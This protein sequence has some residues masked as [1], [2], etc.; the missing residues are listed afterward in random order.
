MIVVVELV[1][2]QTHQSDK[3]IN[4]TENHW[5]AD[6]GDGYY[7]NP[8]LKGDW[9][10]P[11]VLR[12]GKDYY[13]TNHTATH[14]T[15]SMLIWHSR[16]LVNWEPLGYALN[17]DL[18]APV[19]AA[20][21][22]KYDDLYY[23][24]LPV[25]NKGTIYVITAPDPAGPW[26]KP[27]D[28]GVSGID[29]G[30][31]A[32]PDGRRFLHVDAGYM[33]EL[34]SDGLRATTS[35]EKVHNGWEYPEDWIVECFCLES[36]KLFYKDGWYYLTVAQGGTAG[37]P[38]GHMIASS[39]SR[40]PYG[41]WEDSPFNPIV[42][43]A[44]RLEK[45]ASMGHG[46]LIDTPEGEWYVIFHSF[47]NTSRN[48]GRQVLM[49]PI[50]WTKEGWFRVPENIHPT[51]RIKMPVNGER[52]QSR[53][54]LS[55]SFL[56]DQLGLQ[57]KLVGSD[58]RERVVVGNGYLELISEGHSPSDS[59]PLVVD[60]LNDFYQVEVT[61]QPSENARNG[62]ILY[63]NNKRYLGL[64]VDGYSLY[65]IA[66]GDYHR[67]MITKFND[68]DIIRLRLSNDHGDLLYWYSKDNGNTW[69][70]ID[71]V[72]NLMSFGGMTIRPGIYSSG[73]SS[74]IF[75]DFSYRG[76]E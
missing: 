65:R 14:S 1:Y 71:F 27:I 12:V 49:L 56:D 31:I 5:I 33:V 36:P 46:T 40:T 16:D 18:G 54:E 64:E 74:G 41:P 68:K 24:Y 6:Q 69:E 30:H 15:P 13:M 7:I 51:D 23:I 50:E 28:V 62:L 21:F 2:A 47:D 38:T 39:R 17:E 53:M 61:V 66:N 52:V 59:R 44:N 60:P 72:N 19:W 57:W 73:N 10:D 45:W 34:S 3:M 63:A 4:I 76:I 67:E 26:S 9:G 58:S 37:P 29:P 70:R 48:M 55:D 32:T 35:K 25:P 43:T 75:R 42:K 20:D 8:I 22:I 11:T